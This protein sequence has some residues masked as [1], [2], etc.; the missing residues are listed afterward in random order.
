MGR[1]TSFPRKT[2]PEEPPPESRPKEQMGQGKPDQLSGL[3]ELFLGF[4]SQQF[5]PILLK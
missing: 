5:I 3:P 1:P 4:F 2:A